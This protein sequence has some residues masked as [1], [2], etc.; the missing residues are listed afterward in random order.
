MNKGDRVFPEK[1]TLDRTPS[2]PGRAGEKGRKCERSGRPGP[3]GKI[4]LDCDTGEGP[5][6]AP[7]TIPSQSH[8][9]LSCSERRNL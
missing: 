7:A 8:K 5:L 2:L 3:P 4:D 6:S 9:A 1:V